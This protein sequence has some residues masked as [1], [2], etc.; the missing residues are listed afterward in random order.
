MTTLTI[1]VVELYS[2][3][4]GPRENPDYRANFVIN[5]RAISGCLKLYNVSANRWVS[6]SHFVGTNWININDTIR[7][8]ARL[9]DED[10]CKGDCSYNNTQFGCD[11]GGLCSMG[12]GKIISAPLGTEV[13]TGVDYFI[14]RELAPGNVKEN[15]ITISYCDG[16]YILR[17]EVTYNT[18]APTTPKITVNGTAMSSTYLCGNPEIRV[19]TYTGILNKYLSHVKYLWYY[20]LNNETYYVRVQNPEYCDE[21]DICGT[22]P[23]DRH[24]CCDQ[25]EFI[26]QEIVR[27][28]ELGT[29]SPADKNNGD[30]IALLRTLPALKSENSAL[31][32]KVRAVANESSSP[33]VLSNYINISPSAPDVGAINITNSCPNTTDGKIVMSDINGYVNSYRYALRPGFNNTSACDPELATCLTVL[34]TGTA[35]NG[36]KEIPNIAPGKYTLWIKN[37]ATNSGACFATFNVEVR[38]YERLSLIENSREEIQC[39]G[40]ST[41]ILQLIK[42][43]GKPPFEFSFGRKPKNE[44]GQF[45]NISAGSYVASVNDGCDQASSYA[46]TTKTVIFTQPVKISEKAILVEDATCNLPG[47]GAIRVAVE[48][49]SGPFDLN[50]STLFDYSLRGTSNYLATSPENTWNQSNINPGAYILTV[51]QTGVQECNGL[52]K[53]IQI[54]PPKKIEVIAASSTPT[55]CYGKSDGELAFSASGGSSVF[56]FSLNSDGTKFTNDNGVFKHLKGGKY[57][58]S[59]GNALAGCMDNYYIT[60]LYEVKEPPKIEIDLRV[61][62]ITC[63]GEENGIITSTVTGGSGNTSM[64]WEK[65]LGSDWKIISTKNKVDNLNAGIYRLSVQDEKECS[66]ISDEITLLEPDELKIKNV[67]LR[68][69]KCVGET[70]AIDVEAQGGTTPF[71]FLYKKDDSEQIYSHSLS[72][73]TSG[74]YD[75][76]LKDRFG[77]VVNL[78]EKLTITEPPTK[79]TFSEEISNYNGVNVSCKGGSDGW[80]RLRASGGNGG[81]F[82]G[83]QY[84]VNSEEVDGLADNLR[85]GK[86][87]LTAIDG[88]GC[89]VRKEIELRESSEAISINLTELNF[90]TCAQDATGRITVSAGGGTPPYDYTANDAFNSSTGTFDKLSAR[91]Y[92]VKVTDRNK[93]PANLKVNLTSINPPI[94]INAS[95]TNKSCYDSNDG[96]IEIEEIGGSLPF[97][98]QWAH[99]E[100][101][102]KDVSNLS[103]GKYRL[104]VIDTKGCLL[105][106]EWQIRGPDKLEATFGVKPV[107]FGQQHG[108]IRVSTRGGIPPFQYSWNGQPFKDEQ[109]FDYAIPG[110]NRIRIVDANGC[111]KSFETFVPQKTTPIHP[112]FL[113]STQESA[114]DTLAIVDISRPKSDLTRWKIDE[115]AQVITLEPTP[116]VLFPAAG[117]YSVS[118]TKVFGE[119]EYVFTKKITIQEP[120]QQG[121]K[122]TDPSLIRVLEVTPNPNNGKFSIAINLSRP[123]RLCIQVIDIFGNIRYEKKLEKAD[124]SNEQVS[125]DG[126]SGVYIVRLITASQSRD[127]RI[128]VTK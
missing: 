62:P 93:C 2:T 108:S 121:Y 67:I 18:P 105:E 47:N 19:S 21:P 128:I 91:I 86:Y 6:T 36:T 7:I 1:R 71:G 111:T 53:E 58:I 72:D 42:V 87:K 112:D 46:E 55:S 77:C 107:C 89:S 120:D 103:T 59:I 15:L 20:N 109:T 34:A 31:L 48:K 70:G 76:Q 45:F 69:I 35:S 90:P 12:L 79:L 126:A 49:S 40:D 56:S 118:M 14:P 125:I 5:N 100:I 104:R 115:R 9:W 110:T 44:T 117:E 30:L 82:N 26:E 10:G 28:N 96:R 97:T 116:L 16:S 29:T 8:G 17:F 122:A 63:H 22:T 41:G 52:Q 32:L 73:L 65:K 81:N 75:V 124:V 113:V 83:Y 95:V 84:Y 123:S 102:E 101:L 114:L 92:N 66:E 80:V 98:Y 25:P 88:R 94:E 24:R 13:K 3:Y 33:E 127:T 38:S 60:D 74:T 119:C 4:K 61:E 54:N 37:S 64:F 23:R 11:D 51:K 27:W 78:P 106:K 50:S 57:S 68:D 43:G 99:T 85:G 39:N